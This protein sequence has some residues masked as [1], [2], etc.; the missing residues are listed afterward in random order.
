MLGRIDLFSEPVQHVLHKLVTAPE[1]NTKLNGTSGVWDIE[2]DS[3]YDGPL[4]LR[5]L[6]E[7]IC[8]THKITSNEVSMI[9]V[10]NLDGH[11]NFISLNY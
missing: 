8:S 4:K 10:Y 6:R 2:I 3:K 1:V 11:K 9:G 5:G 7:T